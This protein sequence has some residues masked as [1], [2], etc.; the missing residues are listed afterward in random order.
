MK[1]KL[2]IVEDDPNLGDILS[3]YLGLKGFETTLSRDGEEGGKTYKE[4]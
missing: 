3:E 1:P 4:G 2:L